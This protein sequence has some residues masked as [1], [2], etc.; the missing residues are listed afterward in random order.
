M[1]ETIFTYDPTK[2]ELAE[3]DLTYPGISEE[4]YLQD[5]ERRAKHRNSTVQYEAVS[6]L[7]YLFKL[8]SDEQKLNH[9]TNILNDDLIEITN[10]IYNE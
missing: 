9:Y 4:D 5:L 10:K 2:E 1:E 8:R 3:I 6:D 7:Q